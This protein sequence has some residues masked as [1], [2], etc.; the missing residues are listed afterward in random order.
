MNSKEANEIAG[1]KIAALE[2]LGTIPKRLIESFWSQMNNCTVEDHG[3]KRTQFRTMDKSG[4]VY[5]FNGWELIHWVEHISD[6][7]AIR[8]HVFF[9]NVRPVG[10]CAQASVKRGSSTSIEVIQK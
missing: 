3:K 7:R 4:H 6:P 1:D 8:L 2:F 10:V 5:R 9:R